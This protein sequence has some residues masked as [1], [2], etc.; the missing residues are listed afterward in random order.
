MKRVTVNRKKKYSQTRSN[1]IYR[2]Y[3]KSMVIILTN[4]IYMIFCAQAIQIAIIRCCT[5]LHQLLHHSPIKPGA[6]HLSGME[7]LPIR[8]PPTINTTMD[9]TKLLT[10]LAA[11]MVAMMVAT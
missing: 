11:M 6:P 8:L 1:C 4:F 5:V 9:L 2:H 7:L 10:M 3:V